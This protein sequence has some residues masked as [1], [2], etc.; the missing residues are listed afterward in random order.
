VEKQISHRVRDATRWL[1]ELERDQVRK[2]PEPLRFRAPV[3][4]APSAGGVLLSLHGIRVPGRLALG[5]LDVSAGDRL[6][7]TGPNGAGKS[8]LLA[9]IA[10]HLGA[11]VRC[12][13]GGG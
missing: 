7:V 1:A 10:G 13:G 5:R 4:A 3:L 2:P 9:V 11:G 12:T 6:L 8:T